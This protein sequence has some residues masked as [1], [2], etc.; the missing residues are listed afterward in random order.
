MNFQPS[1]IRILMLLC[2]FDGV[3]ASIPS[4]E[5]KAQVNMDCLCGVLGLK[6]TK[7]Q[8]ASTK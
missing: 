3:S 2:C 1:V 5:I 4:F 8:T 7:L 6:P